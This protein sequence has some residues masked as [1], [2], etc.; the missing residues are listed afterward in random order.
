MTSDRKTR[1]N[2]ARTASTRAALL[3]AARAAF[4]GQGFEAAATPE[5]TRAAGVTRGALYHHF[6]D[7][8]DLF[9]AVVRSEAE[10]LAEEIEAASQ[11]HADPEAALLAGAEAYLSAMSRP[12]R[13]RLLLTDGPAVLGPALREIDAAHA[14]RTLAEGLA[15]LNPAM[16]APE[17]DALTALLSA[18]FDR[19]AADIAE[20]AD[21]A[22]YRAAIRR[23]LA[24]ARA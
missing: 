20:G 5:I 12:G 6:A 13:V 2:A 4:A 10:A 16:P 1:S 3:N 11:P 8:A 9:A 23:L 14:E 17:R 15:A 7:K 18:A 21:P 19:A 22:P 24:A